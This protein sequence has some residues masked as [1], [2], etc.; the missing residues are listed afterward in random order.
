L[1]ARFDHQT[2]IVGVL[3]AIVGYQVQ[4]LVF[5]RSITANR[6]RDP[7]PNAIRTQFTLESGATSNIVAFALG[8][9]C[10]TDS[11]VV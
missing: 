10:L 4:T 7:I 6:I 5:C 2:L 1:G 11:V 8:G 9:A 3:F